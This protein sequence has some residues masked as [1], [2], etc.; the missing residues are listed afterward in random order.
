MVRLWISHRSPERAARVNQAVQVSGINRD[1]H[2]KALTTAWDIGA[3]DSN[4]QPLL[5]LGSFD[6]GAR[7]D[8]QEEAIVVKTAVLALGQIIGPSPDDH[9]LLWYTSQPTFAQPQGRFS[10]ATRLGPSERS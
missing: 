2:Q 5:R 1:A 4:R 9:E 3:V 7:D 10:R 8:L 6:K